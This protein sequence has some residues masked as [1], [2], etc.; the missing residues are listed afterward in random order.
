MGFSVSICH[1]QAPYSVCY[2][3]MVVTPT[4]KVPKLSQNLQL[5]LHDKHMESQFIFTI[6]WLQRI[7]FI[8]IEYI[9]SSSYY[10]ILLLSE[11]FPETKL[12]TM[13]FKGT[14]ACIT[15]CFQKHIF[16]K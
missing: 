10:L 11:A 1:I 6:S 12:L 15:I 14:V 13:Y 5:L 2:T 3:C 16:E 4:V 7:Y 8:Y 9:S